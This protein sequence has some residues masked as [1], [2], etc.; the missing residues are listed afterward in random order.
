MKQS[1]ALLHAPIDVEF[2]GVLLANMLAGWLDSISKISSPVEA[3]DESPDHR[4]SPEQTRLRVCASVDAGAS[5]PPSREHQS[6]VCLA[7]ESAGNWVGTS[8]RS[9]FSTGIWVCR[10]PRQQGGK[11]SRPW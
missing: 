9:A 8:R 7:R 6:S 11:T 3:A 4:T 5:S 1:R 10:V 2:G